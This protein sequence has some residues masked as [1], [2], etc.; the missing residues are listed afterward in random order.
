MNDTDHCERHVDIRTLLYA[1]DK[2]MIKR[3]SVHI[4]SGW[5]LLL[6][7]FIFLSEIT[8]AQHIPQFELTKDGIEPIVVTVDSLNAR[9]LYKKALN[10]VK[11]NYKNPVEV[12]KV[13]VKNE[14]VRIEDIKKNVWFYRIPDTTF[15]Y[16]V[17]YLFN[18]DFE[19]NKIRMS[20]D[21]GNTWNRSAQYATHSYCINYKKLWKQDGEVHDIYKETKPG[22]DQMMNELSLSLINYLRDDKKNLEEE[23]QSDWIRLR[24]K[25]KT[26]VIY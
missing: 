23:H 24:H 15:F 3:F 7:S 4:N 1:K 6:V 18:V 19:D 5:Q 10:W 26:K 12:L 2:F 22:I 14:K 25:P 13:D 16:D 20:F 9:Q 11:E 17:E 8:S 21:F